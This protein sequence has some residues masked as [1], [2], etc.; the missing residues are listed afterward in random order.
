MRN[1]VDLER[2]TQIM[3]NI[4]NPPQEVPMAASTTYVNKK[5]IE[6]ESET[7]QKIKKLSERDVQ[8]LQASIPRELKPAPGNMSIGGKIVS[9]TDNK[10]NAYDQDKMRLDL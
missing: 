5:E 10:G 3:G 1:R 7:T 8:T 6:P 4:K 2:T 9:Y